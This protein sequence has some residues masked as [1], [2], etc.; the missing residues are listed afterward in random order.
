[1]KTIKLALQDFALP[2]PRRGSIEPSSGYATTMQKGIELHEKV[3]AD[4]IAEIPDYQIEIPIS[5]SFEKDEYRFEV[6]GRMDG[7]IAGEKPLIEEIKSSFNIF[8]LAKNLKD[9]RYDHP[10]YVQLL[11]YGYF[12]WL[13]NGV[14]PNLSFHLVSSRREENYDLEVYLD[15]KEFE[16]WLDRR[17]DEL[18]RLHAALLAIDRAVGR[19][20]SAPCDRRHVPGRPAEGRRHARR[21]CVLLHKDR[22]RL[23]RV[24]HFAD[25]SGAVG[26]VGI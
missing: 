10:Y 17:L 14:K 6:S 21:V 5:W 15:L 2:A 23:G 16:S 26:R 25:R 4:R 19:E 24:Q 12:Y 20:V 13:N 9:K 18:D 3:Q 7:F 22:A 8:E 1:M 11:S